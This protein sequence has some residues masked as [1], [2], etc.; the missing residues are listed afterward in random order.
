MAVYNSELQPHAALTTDLQER[1][2]DGSRLSHPQLLGRMDAQTRQECRAVW[3]AQN[4]RINESSAR[5]GLPEVAIDDTAPAKAPSSQRTDAGSQ[6]DETVAGVPGDIDVSLKPDGIKF[7]ADNFVRI[8]E[9]AP[10]IK[11]DKPLKTLL[12]GIKSV[13]LEGRKIKIE[14]RATIPVELGEGLPTAQLKLDNATFDIV[15]DRTNPNKVNLENIQGVSIS[16]LG[17][18]G[19]ICKIALTLGQDSNKNPILQIEIPAPVAAKPKSDDVL[20]RLGHEFNRAANSVIPNVT[21]LEIPLG[22][23]GE[24]AQFEQVFGL[25]K[26]LIEAP[27]KDE[28]YIKMIESA[29][30]AK[31]EEP[32]RSMVS[33]VSSFSKEGDRIRIT[34][35]KNTSH[36]LGGLT[37]GVSSKI[38]FKVTDDKN[39][40]KI[41]DIRGIDVKVPIQLPSEVKA[42]GIDPGD[43]LSTSLRDVFVSHPDAAGNRKIVVETNRHLQKVGL[44]L[45]PDMQ[46]AKDAYG[47][48]Y[49]YGFADNPLSGKQLP[50]IL[51]FDGNNQ[52]NMSRQELMRLGAQATWQAA[53]GSASGVGMGIVAVGTEIGAKALDAKDNFFR[54]C[55]VIRSWFWD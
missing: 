33:G 14:G 48:W 31:L 21:K 44:Q 11:L 28:Q 18:G 9:A 42:L 52:L 13:G 49:F 16:A 22:S 17:A 25:A 5:A 4:V 2:D 20:S 6:R 12:E 19:D 34:R 47:N 1:E 39:G 53:D 30:G 55:R 27:K 15:A 35:E 46:P 23:K 3:T 43:H 8:A 50:F 51:R 36:D 41:G 10:G 40:V 26:G 45:G 54:G 38:S 37:L 32:L 29:T 24:A 7:K